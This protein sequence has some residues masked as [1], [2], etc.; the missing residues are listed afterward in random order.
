MG[1]ITPIPIRYTG[2][3]EKD[4]EIHKYNKLMVQVGIAH[5]KSSFWFGVM[6]VCFIL[7]LT[8]FAVHAVRGDDLRDFVSSQ[9]AISG[10]ATTEIEI[11]VPAEV[12]REPVKQAVEALVRVPCALCPGGYYTMP[13]PVKSDQ[14]DNGGADA[15]RRLR[16]FRGRR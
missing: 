2:D 12:K 7:A 8:A 1:A 11:P 9:L 5:A 14:P 10:A 15:G 13:A 3:P 16:L 6:I 4:A